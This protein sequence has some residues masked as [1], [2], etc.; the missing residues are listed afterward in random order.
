MNIMLIAVIIFLFLSAATV[1]LALYLSTIN[2]RREAPSQQLSDEQDALNEE[3]S[4]NYQE[5][6]PLREELPLHEEFPLQVN[7]TAAQL[8]Q[9]EFQAEQDEDDMQDT[10]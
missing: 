3:H 8:Q 9:E 6:P 4:V 1:V 7:D 10:Y 2:W 5:R